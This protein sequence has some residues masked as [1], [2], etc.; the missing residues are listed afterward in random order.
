MRTFLFQTVLIMERR[1]KA[2]LLDSGSSHSVCVL[3]TMS[4]LA[5]TAIRGPK[6][7]VCLFAMD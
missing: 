7:D 1:E 2:G 3:F 6:A 4:F 5:F